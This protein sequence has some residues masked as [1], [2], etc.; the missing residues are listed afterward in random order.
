MSCLIGKDSLKEKIKM[1]IEN[2]SCD[3]E[4][5]KLY[6]NYYKIVKSKKEKRLIIDNMITVLNNKY[7]HI[8]AIIKYILEKNIMLDRSKIDI[9]NWIFINKNIVLRKITIK[10]TKEG[11]LIL[12]KMDYPK[13]HYLDINNN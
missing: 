12:N 10:K 9:Y 5:V 1:A 7:S 3:I 4:I 8:L 11:Y 2:N 13:K 6:S